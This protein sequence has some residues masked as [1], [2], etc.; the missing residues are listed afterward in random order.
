MADRG[1]VIRAIALA[2]LVLGMCPAASAFWGV[3][4]KAVAPLIAPFIKHR[5]ALPDKEILWLSNIARQP[6]GT[7]IVGAELGKLNLP[8]EVL[9]DTYMRIAVQQSTLSRPEAEGMF[10][11]LK[12]TPGL[13]STLSKVV[14][15]SDIK[16]SGHLNEL[17]IADTASQHGYTVNGIGVR[18][19]DGIKKAPTDIDV[20]LQRKNRVIAIEAKDYLPSTRIP[21]DSFRADLMSLS[22]YSKQHP[23]PKVIPVFSMTNRPD[24][25]EDLRILEKEARRH[26]IQLIFGSAQEQITQIKQLQQIL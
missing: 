20:L 15:A 16:T 4:P 1:C 26:G 8:N 18:F 2:F 7:K 5:K 3:A 17:R 21:L 23:S 13:R 14:G 24:N 11:R 12:G 19:D 9:E 6:G 10:T 25:V 22:Q